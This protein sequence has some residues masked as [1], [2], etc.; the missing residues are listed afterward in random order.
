M[1]I[2][3]ISAHRH[4]RADRRQQGESNNGNL[5]RHGA[6][7]AANWRC[8]HALAREII[9]NDDADSRYDL[10][11]ACKAGEADKA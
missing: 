7:L 3:H 5:K 11:Y 8:T 6:E 9:G 1:I 2:I 10:D 4:K